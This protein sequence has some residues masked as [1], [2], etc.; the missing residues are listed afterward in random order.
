MGKKDTRVDIYIQKAQ[1]FA[2]P[3]LL[4]LRELVHKGLP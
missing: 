2:R 3:I 1:P 4:H